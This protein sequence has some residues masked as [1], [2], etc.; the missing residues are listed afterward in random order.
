MAEL[1]FSPEIAIVVPLYGEAANL[2][3]FLN[4]LIPCV[5]SVCKDYRI[6]LVDDGS[7]DETWL[8]ITDQSRHYPKMTG[9]RL[10]RNFGKECAL[11][12]GLEHGYAQAAITMDGDLQHPPELIPEMVNI[13]R[14][15][16]AKVVEAVKRERGIE[17]PLNRFGASV[18]YTV[19][20]IFSGVKLDGMSDFKLLDRQVVE[21]WLRMK[22]RSLFYRGM[23]NWVGFPRAQIDFDVPIR[24]S[25]GSRWSLLGLIRLALNSVTAFSSAPLH[26]STITGLGF[27]IFAVFLGLQTLY[28]KFSGKAVSGFT[29]V[30]LLL[31]IFGS[32]TLSSLGIIGHYLARIYEEV[33]G[34]PR[35]I[36][37]ETFSQPRSGENRIE[38]PQ[39]AE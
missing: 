17:S 38:K 39:M 10:S 16:Q 14:S 25:G 9:I 36:I 34:R 26:L 15:G 33:K 6:I 22:E 13:W 8:T 28:M 31:L 3:H 4:T 27:F 18:F 19:F 35:Y 7:T 1:K 32:L 24:I 5:E 29:T 11:C 30:I 20:R 21:A 2:P 23:I 37:S 12:A